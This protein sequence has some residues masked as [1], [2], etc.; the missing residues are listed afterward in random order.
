MENDN[1]NLHVDNTDVPEI[2]ELS[3]K[4]P[5]SGTLNSDV[6]DGYIIDNRPDAKYPILIFQVISVGFVLIL[7][8]L[9]KFCFPQYFAAAKQWYVANIT[10][11]AAFNQDG[12]K[13]NPDTVKQTAGQ[14]VQSEDNKT[15]S[16]IS[17]DE[18]AENTDRSYVETGAVLLELLNKKTTV[19]DF[20]Y[21]LKSYVITSR[22]GEREDPISGED[23]VHHGIDLAADSGSGIYASLDGRVEKAEY[24]DYYGNYLLLS[25]GSVYTT[26]YGHC[27][28]LLVGVGQSVKKGQKIALVGSTGRSTGPHLHFEI[29]VGGK[30]VNP[31]GYINL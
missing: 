4:I 6:K 23:A 29:S 21:P 30:R 11:S 5:N 28:K 18:N 2:T 1:Q 31:T 9:L 10:S 14:T 8:L 27:E 24:S 13:S 3:D 25:H 15:S 16:D 19:A 26:L 20:G 22:F 7:V 12:E 17:T